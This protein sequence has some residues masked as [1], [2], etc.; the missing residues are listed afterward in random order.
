MDAA[1]HPEKDGSICACYWQHRAMKAAEKEVD[2][3]S[4]AIKLVYGLER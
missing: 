1:T 4:T 3:I 2:E